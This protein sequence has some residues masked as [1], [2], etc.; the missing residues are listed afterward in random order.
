MT[1][2]DHQTAIA[3]LPRVSLTSLPSPLERAAGLERALRSE[4]CATVPRIYLKRDDLLSLG[5]G[6]NKI[7]NLE[8]SIGEALAQGATD[9]ITAGR[10]QS[11]HCRLTAAACARVGL[12]AHLVFAGDRP[13]EHSGNALLDELFGARMYYTG[14]DDRELRASWINMLTAGMEMIERRPY[15]IPVGGSN[16]LG[17]LGHVLAMSE[18]YDQC[19]AIDIKPEAIVL[20][21]ATG[22]TQAGMLVG[23]AAL[24]IDVEIHGYAVAKS[25]DDLTDIVR[26][27]AHEVA[28]MIGRPPIDAKRILIDGSMLGDGYGI[29]S[30]AGDEAVRLLAR[31]EGVVADPVYTGKG[32]A[33]LIALL[34][35]GRFTDDQCVVFLHTGGAPALF[36]H[37]TAER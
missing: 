15:V 28:S 30:A 7:R 24:G 3:R 11:N 32:L 1:A 4:G 16:A 22:G 18:L 17:A 2:E 36:A 25:A 9:I 20:A 23:A 37:T 21:T 31:S 26:A 34:R 10:V 6:G 12:R 8:F 14:N 29:A 19:R 5:L 13:P 33:G 35:S 27:I